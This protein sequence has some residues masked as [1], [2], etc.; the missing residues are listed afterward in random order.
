MVFKYLFSCGS[1]LEFS[2]LFSTPPEGARRS[3]NNGCPTT[4]PKCI[5]NG[6]IDAYTPSTLDPC[7]SDSDTGTTA[8]LRPLMM[9]T[10][11]PHQS[12]HCHHTHSLKGN[13]N[14]SDS[15]SWTSCSA[16]ASMPTPSIP[17]CRVTPLCG[18]SGG[19]PC[20]T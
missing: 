18:S 11:S 8:A 3:M 12:R 20:E 15:G 17:Q 9:S 6:I 1:D 2:E 19:I 10:L 14:R 4:D 7:N 13:S 16:S 5:S